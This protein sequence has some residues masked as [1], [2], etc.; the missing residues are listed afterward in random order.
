VTPHWKS[1]GA[2]KESLR[3]GDKIGSP[4]KSLEDENAIGATIQDTFC[5]PFGDAS[6]VYLQK[7]ARI[8]AITPRNR[9]HAHCPSLTPED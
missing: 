1:G 3:V 9:G 5:L 6:G 8:R 7:T 2:M 4:P